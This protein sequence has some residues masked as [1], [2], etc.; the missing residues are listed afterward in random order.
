MNIIF[1]A[2]LY[3]R[4]SED[5]YA[6]WLR[7]WKVNPDDL[8]TQVQKSIVEEYPLLFDKILKEAEKN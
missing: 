4:P 5:D 7:K 2:P 1:I 8:T 6:V 3:C